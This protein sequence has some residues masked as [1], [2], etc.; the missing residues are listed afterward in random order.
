MKHLWL[1]CVSLAVSP[2][3]LAEEGEPMSVFEKF[4]NKAKQLGADVAANALGQD[5]GNKLF[6]YPMNITDRDPAFYGYKH[7]SVLIKSADNTKLHCWEISSR[8][9]KPKGVVV[10]SHGNTGSMNSHF[11][12]CA[13]LVK[14]GWHVLM[15]DYRGYGKSGGK[16]ERKGMVEDVQAAVKH[17]LSHKSWNH[18]PVVSFGHSLG[19][20]KSIAALSK[21]ELPRRFKGVVAWAGFSSYVEIAKHKIGDTAKRIVTDEFAPQDHVSKLSKPLLIVHGKQ[22]G[23]VPSAHAKAL[24][25]NAK[26][27]KTLLLSNT[28]GHNN[29]FW[30]EQKRMRF[31]MLKWLDKHAHG[32]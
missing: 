24:F 29:T 1:F 13:W 16:P 21:M 32:L 8:V 18:L 10:F 23:V 12:F 20:A 19:A 25:D 3:A 22:D 9:Q 27:P 7:K 26:Q 31:S 11:G 4:K 15:Y 17:A 14:A 30:V 6:Y 2:F 5:G 28:G